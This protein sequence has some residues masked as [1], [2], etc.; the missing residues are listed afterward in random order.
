MSHANPHNT[1]PVP[2]RPDA[3]P[4]IMWG[5]RDLAISLAKYG[6]HNNLPTGWLEATMKVV[7]Q[8]EAGWVSWLRRNRYWSA[9]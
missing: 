2:G 7:M 8:G 5:K 9:P 3:T 4:T 6:Q 1:G